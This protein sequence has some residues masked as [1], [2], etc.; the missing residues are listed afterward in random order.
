VVLY[1][2]DSD[3][4]LIQLYGWER[5]YTDKLGRSQ[6]KA[7]GPK[8]YTSLKTPHPRQPD[9]LGEAI[10]RQVH[11]YPNFP[12]TNMALDTAAKHPPVEGLFTPTHPRRL[13][14]QVSLN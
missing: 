12:R 1:L 9:W 7:S 14:R 10:R 6:I 2:T 4:N 8:A 13:S 5:A 11:P 3:L